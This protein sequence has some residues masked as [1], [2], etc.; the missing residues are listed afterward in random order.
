M[1]D[2]WLKQAQTVITNVLLA[3]RPEILAAHGKIDE[4]LKADDSPVTALDRQLEQQ[5]REALTQ[6][7]A[8]IPIVGEE[9]GGDA[10]ADTFWLIDPIDGTESF[11][12]GLPFF[13]SMVA[14]VQN[15]EPLFTLVYRPT[16]NDIYTAAKGKGAFKNDVQIYASKRPLKQTT[17]DVLAPQYI[18]G[19]MTEFNTKLKGFKRI[20]EFAYV[21]EGKID[22]MLSMSRRSGPWDHVPR[23]LLLQE[24]GLRVGTVGGD[25]FDF[26]NGSYLAANPEIFDELMAIVQRAVAA[27]EAN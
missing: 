23:G 27:T 8:S 3:A 19:L 6:L 16:T 26:R 11:I 5:L 21:A 24:A 9:Y 2:D 7:D 25:G 1:T 15:N 14:L 10:A 18:G 13:R 20:N 17:I 4:E 22:A 12:R